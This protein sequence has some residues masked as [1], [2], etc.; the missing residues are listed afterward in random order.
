MKPSLSILDPT[1]HYVPSVAT[2]V[3][4]TWRRFGWRP[5]SSRRTATVVDRTLSLGESQPG[6]LVAGERVATLQPS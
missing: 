4:D 2:S 3:T 5:T 6:T 1:F